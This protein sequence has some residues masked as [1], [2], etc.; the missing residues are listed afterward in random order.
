MRRMMLVSSLSLGTAVCL[1][2]PVQAQLWHL[3]PAPLFEV[4]GETQ[5]LRYAL[6]RVVGGTRLP[7]GRVVIADRIAYGLKMF[8]PDGEFIREVGG[9]GQGPGEFEYIRG[10]GRCA[11]GRIVGFDIDWGE[12]HY[13]LSLDLVTTRRGETPAVGGSV[14]QKACNEA[15]FVLATGWGDV[16]GRFQVGYHITEA[17]VVLSK[18]SDVIHHFGDRLSSERIGSLDP[19]GNPAGTAPHPFGRQTSVALGPSR[20]YVGSAEDYVIEVYDLQGRRLEDLSWSGPDLDL[21]KQ[22][23]DRFVERRV[24]QTPESRRSSVRRWYRDMPTVDRYPA[25]D[26]L[27][28]DQLGNLWVRYFPRPD[29][30]ATRWRVFDPEGETQGEVEIPWRATLLDAGAEFVLLS[31]PDEWDVPVVRVMGLLKN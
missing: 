19:Q 7:D 2:S 17:P 4:G 16:E 11:E 5:D 13:D 10:M 28:T 21:T 15:G 18:G 6:S 29:S 20:A 31:E 24:E 22:D 14:Y 3:A 25:Y 1:A 30:D 12:N 26:R 9:E 23:V 27:M 8:S